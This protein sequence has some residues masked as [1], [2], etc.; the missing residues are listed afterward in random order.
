[1]TN[2]IPFIDLK[3]QQALLKDEIDRRMQDVLAHGRYIMGPE[4]EE[5]ED[6]LKT[7][8]GAR[9]VVTC[10]SG[11]DALLMALMAE[12]IGPGDAVFVPTFTFTASAEVILLLGATPIYVDVDEREFNIDCDDLK[13]K[14]EAVGK[15]PSLIPRVIMPVDL[16]GLPADYGRLRAIAD[17]NGMMLLG[18]AAQS[19]GGEQNG[20]SV[21]ALADVTATS[22]FPAKPLGCYGDGGAIFTD[23]DERADILRSIRAHGKG[24]AK[25]DIVRVGV[26]GRLDTL[27]A[28]I[29]LAKM[30]RFKEERDAREDL[31][32]Y[33]DS[34]LGNLVDTPRRV[35]GSRSAWA[36]Y[37][38]LLDNRDDV[39]AALKEKGVPTAIYYPLPMHLQSAYREFGEGR[40]SM[41]VSESLSKRILSLP[42]HPYMDEATRARICD[43][44][45]AIL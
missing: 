43:E 38:I 30:T 28:A 37:S 3:A 26:N 22:F 16:F 44:L 32:A 15:D 36:Q 18:D 4:I 39:A 23:D 27:Q 19:F 13:A 5:F 42:M 17:R 10:S 11:S 41:P 1:M 8:T 20:V 2:P 7:F 6:A 25:Y 45:A 31:A 9:N 14:I 34:R 12:N 35:E 33:Y 40:G 21:G 29:L 24:G